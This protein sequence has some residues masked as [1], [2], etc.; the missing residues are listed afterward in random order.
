MSWEY[1]RIHTEATDAT[2]R[3]SAILPKQSGQI[4]Q[5]RT[6]RILSTFL[7]PVST[8][9]QRAAMA[10][11]IRLCE[12]GLV[13]FECVVRSCRLSVGQS[14]Y[15]FSKR[16]VGDNRHA[17]EKRER[18]LSATRKASANA[19][20]GRSRIY[21]VPMNP[22]P[23]FVVIRMTYFGNRRHCLRRPVR[24]LHRRS[25]RTGA[26][27]GCAFKFVQQPRY[28]LSRT[29]SVAVLLAIADESL[30]GA[31]GFIILIGVRHID[32]GHVLFTAVQQVGQ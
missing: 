15:I 13:V 11:I 21:T 29:A 32:G 17:S 24:V 26:N 9:L 14:L 19:G 28:R 7:A 4:R 10:S 20:I 12:R 6:F 23:A 30:S 22:D 3:P 2:P 8:S 27:S 1:H 18:R 25:G 5:N 16:I 31:E